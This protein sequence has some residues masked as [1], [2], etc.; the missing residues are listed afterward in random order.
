[1]LHFSDRIVSY[2]CMLGLPLSNHE[3]DLLTFI[4][5]SSNF[6]FF[7]H[8]EPHVV[9]TVWQQCKVEHSDRGKTE[10]MLEG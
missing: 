4:A 6:H 7:Y 10:F 8:N 2:C 9:K 3:F 5:A 1:M